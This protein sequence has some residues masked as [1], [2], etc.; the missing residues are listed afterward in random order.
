M[1]KILRNEIKT[2]HDALAAFT[3]LGSDRTS[4][5]AAQLKC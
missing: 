3:A 2:L 4:G 1:K 5:A